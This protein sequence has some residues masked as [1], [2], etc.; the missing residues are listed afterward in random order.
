[1]SSETKRKSR[2]QFFDVVQTQWGIACK[3]L[4]NPTDQIPVYGT[5]LKTPDGIGDSIT[6]EEFKPILDILRNDKQGILEYINE[7]SELNN[8]ISASINEEIFWDCD[9]SAKWLYERRKDIRQYVWER[10]E[11]IRTFLILKDEP[12]IPESRPVDEMS[13]I[14]FG[15]DLLRPSARQKIRPYLSLI[16]ALRE[17]G[18]EMP[19]IKKGTASADPFTVIAEFHQIMHRLYSVIRAANIGGYSI[20]DNLQNTLLNIYCNAQIIKK[21]ADTAGFDFFDDGS[22]FADIEKVV[23]NKTE[24]GE[25][26]DL[27]VGMWDDTKSAFY[28]HNNLREEE[29]ILWVKSFSQKEKYRPIKERAKRSGRMLK[30]TPD[31]QAT[32]KYTWDNYGYTKIWVENRYRKA[33]HLR[34]DLFSERISIHNADKRLARALNSLLK[35]AKGFLEQETLE[36]EQTA[37]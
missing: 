15:L 27:P 26:T 12:E 16:N 5:E 34:A 10:S 30:Q 13:K 1:M 19:S 7:Q 29:F 14:K 21:K 4:G 28:V 35:N 8:Y 3:R 9:K 20:P 37:S 25:E 32:T 23:K 18:L 17:C 2:R 31:E 33:N 22:F 6:P 11:A 24:S 36:Q